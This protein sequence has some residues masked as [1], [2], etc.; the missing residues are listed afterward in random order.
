MSK[1]S[2]LHVT[3]YNSVIIWQGNQV[4]FHS[5]FVP[6]ISSNCSVVNVLG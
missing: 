3:V 4:H 6:Y 1:M 2:H 5:Q